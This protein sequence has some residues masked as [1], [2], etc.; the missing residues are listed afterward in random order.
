MIAFAH[1]YTGFMSS[2]DWFKIRHSSSGQMQIEKVGVGALKDTLAVQTQN[3]ESSLCFFLYFARCQSWSLAFTVQD[4]ICTYNLNHVDERIVESAAREGG[5]LQKALTFSPTSRY[6]STLGLHQDKETIKSTLFS[7]C[8]LS[9][10]LAH[11][12]GWKTYK[13]AIIYRYFDSL[14]SAGMG[15]NDNEL[16]SDINPKYDELYNLLSQM[17]LSDEQ[18]ARMHVKV[19]KCFEDSF[20]EEHLFLGLR[21]ICQ[22][23]DRLVK[24]MPKSQLDR[25]LSYVSLAS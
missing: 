6:Q 17:K 19:S 2:P 12:L 18:H 3:C 4:P 8:R 25:R 1:H 16:D 5:S 11:L 7:F 9:G 13:Q 10:R 21:Y 22:N 23:A 24:T 20:G 14:S 15:G